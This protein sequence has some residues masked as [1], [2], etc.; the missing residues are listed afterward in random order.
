MVVAVVGTGSAVPRAEVG[1]VAE[2]EPGE[3]FSLK[4]LADARQRDGL[5]A[6]GYDIAGYNL[7]EGWVEVLT[8][9]KGLARLREQGFVVEILEV[10]ERPIPLGG[11]PR[12]PGT[13][14][15]LGDTLY[16]DPGELETFLNQVVL[17]HPGITRLEA[18]GTSHEGRTIWGLLIS[19]N[20]ALEEDELSVLF[21]GA[22]HAREVMSVEVVMDI[23]DYLTDHY[24]T[25]PEVTSAI[26]SYGVWCVPMVNPDG[27]DAVFTFDQDWRKNTLDND[28]SGTR[29]AGDGVDLNRNYEWGFGNQCQGSSGGWGSDVYRGPSEGSEPEVQAMIALGRR[30]RPVFDVE[31]HS[32]GEA[33]WYATSCDPTFSPTLTTIPGGEPTIG[34]VIGQDYASRIVQA[35]G[36]GTGF[37]AAPYGDRVDGAGRDQQ[38]H[39]NGAIAFVTEINSFGEGGFRPSYAAWRAPTVAGQRPGWLWLLDRIDGAAIGGHVRDSVTHLPLAADIALDELALRDGQR[40][41][42]RADNGRFHVIVVPGDY[43]LRVTAPGYQD[44]SASLTVGSS[45]SPL[46][47]DLVPSGSSRIVREEFEV[48]GTVAAWTF[49]DPGDDA[50]VGL[51]EWGEP[52]GTHGGTIQGGNLQFGNPGFDRTPRQGTRALVT[53]TEIA[54]TLASDDVDG[55]TTTVTSPS[56]NLSGWYGVS[57]S[58]HRWLRNSP[59][60]PADR[61][62]TQVSVNGGA[63]WIMVEDLSSPTSTPNAVATWAETSARLDDLVAPGADVRLRFRASDTGIDN[64]VEAAIDDLEIR[65]YSLIGQGE[66]GGMTLSG[67]SATVLQWNAVTGAP[68]ATFDVVRGDLDRLT[69]SVNL[70]PLTCIEDDSPDASTSGDADTATPASGKGFFYVVRFELG[71]SVGGYGRGSGGGTRTGTGGCA[72]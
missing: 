19:D 24:G 40:L 52:Q 27:V 36:G 71:Y 59:L 20:A 57:V 1:T 46:M 61:L 60:D 51:W 2:P 62:E 9:R 8:D 47:V 67:K 63:A 45:F 53:G 32:Y 70:G 69:G 49:G 23:I 11:D 30:I 17:D 28:G 42:S 6:A 16:T 18:L 26:D 35:D 22:H 29:T 13:D 15:V 34:R 56:F 72:P 65:G 21:S 12:A 50:T 44:G 43:T 48:P 5:S 37:Y 14:V 64:V 55:G 10:R 41:T 3:R 38:Y 7:P 33:V 54:G 31:Y 66:I 4:V 58:W 68:D 39:E 25:L